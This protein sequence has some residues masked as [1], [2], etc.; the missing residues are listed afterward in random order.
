MPG[1]HAQTGLHGGDYN[2]VKELQAARAQN[3]DLHAKIMALHAEHKAEMH[4]ADE[5]EGDSD[6]TQARRCT[7]C[8]LQPTFREKKQ[9]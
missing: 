5:T 7:P 2:P 6:D 3:A 9:D 1:W 8:Q 4:A